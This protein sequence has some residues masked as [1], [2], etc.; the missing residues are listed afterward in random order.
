MKKRKLILILAIIMEVTATIQAVEPNKGIIGKNVIRG[1]VTDISSKKPLPFVSVQLL[2]DPQAGAITDSLGVFVINNVTL[3][4]HT[5]KASSIGYEPSLV[6]EVLVTS[7]RDRYVEISMV[8]NI[9]Q[10]DEIIVRPHINK[11][12]PL[13]VMAT[14]GARMFSVEEASRYAGGFDD[15][16]R[17]A[18]SFSGVASEGSTNGISIHGNAPHLL[19]WK[20]EGIEIPNPN[21]FADISI[22]GGGVFSSLSSFVLGN[23]DFFTGAFPAEYGNAVSGVFDMK[24]RNGNDR[25]N[26]NAFQVGIAGIDF[27][28]EGP[29]NKEKGSSYLVNYRYS[30][31]GLVDKV[32]LMDMDGQTID[33][34]DLN[35]KLNFPT[36]K[37][38][39][40]SVWGTGL[41][42]NYK[43]EKSDSTEWK[44]N[45]DNGCSLSKQYMVAGG[46]THSYFFPNGG[47]LKS[48]IAA[49]YFKENASVDTYNNIMIKEPY[50]DIHRMYSNIVSDISYTRKI[51]PRLTNK[52]GLTFTEM[53]YD[54]HMDKAENFGTPLGVV[55]KGKGNTELISGYSSFAWRCMP[56]FTIN[57]GLNAQWLALNNSATVEPRIGVKWQLNQKQSLAAAYGMYSRSEKTDVYFVR[58]GDVNVNENLGFTKAH[59]FML[60]YSM[61]IA[62]NLTLKVEPYCQLLFNVPVE[63]GSS[64]SVLNRNDFYLDKALVNSGNGRSYGV[65]FTLERYLENGWYGM[66]TGS[67]FDSKYS[68]GDEV[69]RNTRYNRHYII[70][71][72]VGKEWMV[73]KNKQNMFSVNLRLTMQGGENYSPIDF[74][75]TIAHPDHEVQY[76]ETRAFSCHYNPE[77]LMHYTISYKVNKKGLSHEFSIKHVNA[78]GTKS[79]WGHRYNFR[80]GRIEAYGMAFSLPNLSYK[81]EF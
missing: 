58:L 12:Q 25:Y 78:T 33:Y 16:A 55:Y 42:D 36:V 38:G 8:E 39:T 54:M 51:T 34:Q 64:Y 27:A 65:D 2:D 32:G 21:H 22:L 53:I 31:T 49:T 41:I 70:N 61:S 73:G 13:N 4:R 62:E 72:L 7:G 30:M 23:S 44:F 29:I 63:N 37:S 46:G 28:S 66:L 59:H 68:G 71:S 69:W 60:T 6:K 45:D 67:I 80:T 1:V 40:F 11:E 76:D 75:K 20:M 48:S 19:M 43:N 10:I 26:E 47:L 35:F 50:M 81:L 52:S 56:T 15:P 3:G 74:D 57:F 5:I 77:L 79:Y 9:E 14:T 17:L 18:S 24:M